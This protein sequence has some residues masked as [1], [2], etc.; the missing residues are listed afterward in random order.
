M[1]NVSLFAW[2][3]ILGPFGVSVAQDAKAQKA[4]TWQMAGFQVSTPIFSQIVV[5]N[6]PK[7]WKRAHEQASDRSY[8]MEF[9][10]VDQKLED[11]KEMITVQGF[12]DLA[13]A[14][15][16][17]SKGLIGML[18]TNIKKACGENTVGQLL[19]DKKV[20]SFEASHAFM[21]CANMAQVDIKGI[22][23]KGKS[24]V[25]FY[26]AIKGTN[27]MYMIHRS[28]RGDAFNP[29]QIPVTQTTL[30]AWIMGLQPIKIC[31][32]DPKFPASGPQPCWERAAR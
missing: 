19:G 20:D 14:P 4:A 32:R 31:E 26:I 23:N 6:V 28:V 30:D 18:A 29:K 5:F 17:T 22:S 24:D 10:P 11:W 8:I 15:N 12:K 25:A 7:G 9:I 16:A 13:K 1:K 21:G 2:I 3:F 27:D